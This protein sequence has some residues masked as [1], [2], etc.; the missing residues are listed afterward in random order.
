MKKYQRFKGQVLMMLL[1]SKFQARSNFRVIKFLYKNVAVN[2]IEQ[3]VHVW[4]L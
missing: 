4:Y 3:L 2:I 1:I